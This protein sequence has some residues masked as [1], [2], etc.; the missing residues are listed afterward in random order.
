MASSLKSICDQVM[1]ESGFLLPAAYFG[2]GEDSE[3]VAYVAN[4]ASDALRE[5]SLQ[6]IRKT[7][8]VT[9]SSAT[10]YTL[11]EDFLAYVPDTAFIDGRLDPVVL[12]TTPQEWNFMLASGTNPGLYYRARIL[13]GTLQVIN[14][15]AGDVLRY[16]YVSNAPWTDSAGF[17]PKQRA[18]ADTDLCLFDFRTMVLGTKWL[19]K[20]EKGLPDWEIDQAAYAR[21]LN[22]L[23]GRNSGARTL[24]DGGPSDHYDP[25]P[26][27]NLW[28]R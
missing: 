14:P 12:P 8:T 17:N 22:S 16:E 5:D 25:Q 18:T 6:E 1:G 3:Q 9:L 19:W 26:Q 24:Y 11:P 7:G 21:Q 13:G 20:K 2:S 23:R 15:N 4:A 28:V 10:S 27:T